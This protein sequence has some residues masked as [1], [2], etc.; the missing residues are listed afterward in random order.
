MITGIID[1]Q[2]EYYA[3]RIFSEYDNTW[4]HYRDLVSGWFTYVNMFSFHRV[5]HL[6]I[7]S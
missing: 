5:K 2:Y 6:E 4:T 3:D 7:C 1:Y